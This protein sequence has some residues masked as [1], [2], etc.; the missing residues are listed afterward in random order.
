MS[1]LFFS[2]CGG[3]GGGGADILGLLKKKN[4]LLYFWGVMLTAGCDFQAG[5]RAVDC[6]TATGRDA[7]QP[8]LRDGLLYL[9]FSHAN[10]L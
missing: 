6:E 8:E 3:A 4:T 1:G 2:W 10:K 9:D 5:V 7:E